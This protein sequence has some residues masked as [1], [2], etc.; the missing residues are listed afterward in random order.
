MTLGVSQ[1]L[2]SLPAIHSG[3]NSSFRQKTSPSLLGD[4]FG[5]RKIM[6]TLGSWI[7][8]FASLEKSARSKLILVKHIQISILTRSHSYML[9][10]YDFY[11]CV[12]LRGSHLGTCIFCHGIDV[13]R[14]PINRPTQCW[15][16]GTD[17]REERNRSQLPGKFLALYCSLSLRQ[18]R[19]WGHVKSQ[20]IYLW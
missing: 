6:C 7:V 15:S 3:Q 16:C 13:W 2:P 5:C 12:F 20:N 18:P 19:W 11:C 10:R 8:L 1:I 17:Q 14:Q 9:R 4:D